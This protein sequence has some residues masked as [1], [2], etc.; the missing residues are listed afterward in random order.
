MNKLI[1][2]ASPHIKSGTTTSRIMQDV[3]IAL[4]PASIA[5]VV[6]FGLRAL[7]VIAVSVAASVL[8]EW[9]YEKVTG[10]PNTVGDCSAAVT[11]LLLALSL[12]V[13][14]PLWQV[15]LGDVVAIIVV[16]QLFG[17]IG[18]N[19]ANPAVTARIVLMLAFTAAATTWT[20]PNFAGA[21]SSVDAVS[22]ATPLALIESGNGASLPS[23]PQMLLGIHM[24]CLG[25]TC[26][27]ALLL[28]GIYLM[29][30]RVISWHTPVAFLGT[31]FVCTALLGQAPVYQVLSGGAIIGAFFM[32]TDYS[33]TP[34]TNLGRILFGIGCGLL[35]TVIRVYG[36]YPEGVSF[37]I[38]LMNIATPYL[39]RLTRHKALGGVKA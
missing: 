6:L 27:V 8:A 4:V 10:R 15:V 36:N 34:S 24:G 14:M 17:G 1:V 19:F 38:L 7:L 22:S 33:T 16:K 21:F 11:G 26:S 28:G 32:A 25:E 3:L 39:S 31:L 18:H 12:P 29:V 5:A 9:L 35:T 2:T 37:S 13:S 23:L 30:R 20:Q